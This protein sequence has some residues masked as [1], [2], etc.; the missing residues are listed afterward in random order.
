VPQWLGRSPLA[1]K[2]PGS[3]QLA[4]GIFRKLSL[5]TQQ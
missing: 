2:V 4:A 3:K 1:L 5:F